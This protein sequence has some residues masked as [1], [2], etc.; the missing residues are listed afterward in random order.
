[1]LESPERVADQGS[2]SLPVVRK[3]LYLISYAV[4]MNKIRFIY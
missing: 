1:M 2:P 4:D 3:L